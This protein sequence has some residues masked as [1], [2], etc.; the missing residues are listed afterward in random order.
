MIVAARETPSLDADLASLRRVAA[1]EP[2][3]P[4]IWRL[5]ADHLDLAGDRAG[6]A[7]AYLAHVRHAIHDSG[8]MAAAAA[9]HDNRIPDA[10]TR[11]RAQL[12][13]APTDVV[14]IRMLAEL[15]M[16]LDRSDDA[17]RLLITL[18]RLRG[19]PRPLWQRPGP[20]RG[21]VDD[22]GLARRGA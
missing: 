1:A 16:R 3:R 11:L 14:A 10:E 6:A 17:E 15:A 20:V 19:L 22:G 18:H 5:L 2:K 13:Q 7:Q 8:L 9:L 12:K 4:Q 21:G